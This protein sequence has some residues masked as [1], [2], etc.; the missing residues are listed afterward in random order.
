[1]ST[2]ARDSGESFRELGVRCDTSQYRTIRSAATRCALAR[3]RLGELDLQIISLESL[4]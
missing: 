2:W 3:A 4:T 1:M